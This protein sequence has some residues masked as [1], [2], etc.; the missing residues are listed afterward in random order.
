LCLQ[1]IHE[2]F[3][4]SARRRLEAFLRAFSRS[5]GRDPDCTLAPALVHMMMLFCGQ[6][7]TITLTSQLVSAPPP[8]QLSSSV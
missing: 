2:V 4:E 6:R 8:P 3:A 1:E 5:R 7:A